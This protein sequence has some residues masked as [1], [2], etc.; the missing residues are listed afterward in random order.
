[1]GSFLW[2]TLTGRSCVPGTGVGAG[3]KYIVLNQMSFNIGPCFEK[4][5]EPKFTQ[6]LV[7]NHG[8]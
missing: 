7:Q 4:E 1:M 3:T 8:I 5:R 6:W 2:I